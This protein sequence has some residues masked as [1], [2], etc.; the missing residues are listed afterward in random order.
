MANSSELE[1]VR[2]KFAVICDCISVPDVV[3]FAGELL[4]SNLITN[5]GHQAAIAVNASPPAN[6]VAHLVSEAMNNVRNSPDNFYKFV[7]IL[8]SRNAQLA[9]AL[10]SDYSERQACL[11]RPKPE[12][13]SVNQFVTNLRQVYRTAQ[14]PTWD[15]LPQCQHVKLAMIKEKGKRCGSDKTIAESRVE[16][17]VDKMLTIKVPVDS[18]R[19]FDAGAFDDERQVIL[20]EGVGGMGKTSLAYQ[21][22][23]KWAEEKLSTFDA[24]ALVRLRDLNEDDEDEFDDVDRILPR[25][26]FLA[27]GNRT[28]KEMAR[29]IVYKQR[30][31]L[32]LD[33]WDESPASIRK[34]SFIIDLLRS[35]SSQTRIL[36]TSRPDVSLDLHGLANRVEI[37]GFTKSDIHDYFENALKSHLPNGEVKSACDKLCS[38]FHR[39]PVIESCCYVPLNA[40]IL[41]YIY[42]NHDQTLPITRCELFQLQELV[43]CC[44]VR[45]LETRR[46]DRMLED[47]SSFEDFPADLKEELYNLSELA[48]KGVMQ[49]KIVFTQKEL[50]SL[51]TLGLLHI[52]QGF[53]SIG[54]KSVTCN[55]IHLAV[56]EL[57]AAY[58]ISRLE[59]AEHSKQFQTLLNDNLKFPVLQF[60]SGLTGLTNESV[61]NLITGYHFDYKKESRFCLLTFLNCIFEAQIHDQLFFEQMVRTLNSQ[62]YLISISLSPMDCLSVHYFL[63]SIRTVVTGQIELDISRCSID[64]Q[65]LGMLLGISTEHAETS[66]TSSV[67]E[68]VETLIVEL[69]KYTDTGMAY[70]ARALISN[71]TLKS[72]RVGNDSITDLGLVPL[73]EAVP[74]LNSLS[75]LVLLC[76][77]SHP[78]RT[79][80]KI[81]ECVWRS[82]LRE[83]VLFPCSP[84]LQSE[85][86]VKEW[87]QSV[88]V[89]GNSLI[90]TLEHGQLSKLVLSISILCR[91][92][93]NDV[94]TQLRSS[95]QKTMDSI[96]LRRVNKALHS[97]DLFV[98]VR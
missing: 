73:L 23:K 67:L 27:S 4:Q 11:P 95:L 12:D 91:I 83:L 50:T 97:I 21:Y 65:C 1:T 76:S 13:P 33:G 53:G 98:F 60:Y 32:I 52:V 72:L 22:A 70:I 77:L 81:G 36:I 82:T 88:V 51:S 59:P 26:L 35:V 45:E 49:N 29:L 74:R 9:S 24:V 14:P 25:L 34:P 58:Y 31:L 42:L 38:H 10:R 28:S 55:F 64:D 44:I 48:F 57:L 56:Q 8:E 5:V 15:P 85:E 87:V 41:A 2:G 37:L 3:K 16:G 89:G 47:V 7:S 30:I 62:I 18:E 78:D 54:R 39:Y 96:N 80:L 61:R 71:N 84:S 79:L 43:L 20:V 86:A 93:K 66:C 92:N 69:N 40:A 68:S 94:K 90:L 6:K 75:M 63:S 46:P 17:D 19:I